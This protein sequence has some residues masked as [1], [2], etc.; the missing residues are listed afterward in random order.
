MS[1][2]AAR[3]LGAITVTDRA[4]LEEAACECYRAIRRNFE[5]LLPETYA[6][7]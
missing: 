4:G 7:S 5:R 3:N 1:W 6:Q 2:H